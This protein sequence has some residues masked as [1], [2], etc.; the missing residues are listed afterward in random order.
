M[1]QKRVEKGEKYWCVGEDMNPLEAVCGENWAL[2]VLRFEAGNCYTD[3]H[4][5]YV[6]CGKLR[7]V[8][9]G[10]D[11]I[12]LPSEREINQESVWNAYDHDGDLER[13][14]CEAERFVDG[15]NWLKTKIVKLYE[16]ITSYI[17]SSMVQYD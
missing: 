11:V 12:Q 2:D 1:K 3:Y 7:A 14:D 13:I 5:C 8:L 9:A 10:A 17:E 6:M 4:E 16:N 15:V